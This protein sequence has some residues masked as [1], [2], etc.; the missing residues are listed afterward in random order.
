[1]KLTK[2]EK[3]FNKICKCGHKKG[4]HANNQCY[5]GG[6]GREYFCDCKCFEERDLEEAHL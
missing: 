1:M 3:D 6:Y 4:H 2:K 5:G